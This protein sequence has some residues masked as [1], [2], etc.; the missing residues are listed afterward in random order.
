[1]C[2]LFFYQIV[3][4]QDKKRWINVDEDPND[5]TNEFKPPP[6][7]AEMMPKPAPSNPLPGIVPTYNSIGNVAPEHNIPTYD[8]GQVPDQPSLV[9]GGAIRNNSAPSANASAEDAVNIVKSNQPNMFK[10][11]RG[12]SKCIDLIFAVSSL[13]V[14]F[15]ADLKN[16]Y[17]DVFNPGGKSSSGPTSLPPIDKLP[18]AVPQMNFFIPQHV[19][20]PNAPVDFLT[21]GGVPQLAEQ[22]VN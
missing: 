19:T 3:W 1:M 20:D 21:P 5:P 22:Q 11:Q 16:S 6:K 4:D 14:D 13:N 2:K 17:V 9:P 12:R 7:M 18:S 15:Y 10:L 8:V